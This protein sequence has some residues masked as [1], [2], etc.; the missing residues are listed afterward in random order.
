[1]GAAAGLF[2]TAGE[3][4]GVTGPWFIGIARQNSVD[5]VPAVAMLSLVAL[6]SAVACWWFTRSGFFNNA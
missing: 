3:L 5:F 1:M 6:V 2:F 4:G